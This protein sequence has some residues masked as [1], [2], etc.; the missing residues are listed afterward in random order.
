M[1]PFTR[2]TADE[3]KLATT[4]LC[5]VCFRRATSYAPNPRYVVPPERANDRPPRPGDRRSRIANIA[6]LQ[7]AAATEAAQSRRIVE[8]ALGNAVAAVDVPIAFTAI[9]TA[10]L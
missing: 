5:L 9:S 8:V 3:R 4:Y 1:T 10:A 2:L 6:A 7:A